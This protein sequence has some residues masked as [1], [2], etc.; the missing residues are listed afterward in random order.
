MSVSAVRALEGT[1][2]EDLVAA[3]HASL[4]HIES[5]GGRVGKWYDVE[6]TI[7]GDGRKYHVNCYNNYPSQDAFHAAVDAIAK[8]PA[9]AV[10][11]DASKSD[12]Y[13]VLVKANIDKITAE[14]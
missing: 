5:V 14:V 4:A 3:L 9:C 10:L 12:G 8:D 2:V 11:A 1:S 13:T 7:I 6:G